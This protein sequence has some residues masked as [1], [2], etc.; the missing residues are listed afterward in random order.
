MKGFTVGFAILVWG[1]EAPPPPVQQSPGSSREIDWEAQAE[2]LF[3]R[4]V[5]LH[6]SL[7]R[8]VIQN[9]VGP[10]ANFELEPGTDRTP[11]T[12]DVPADRFREQVLQALADLD[13][14]VRWRTVD[15]R[16][17][18]EVGVTYVGFTI[19]LR[20]EQQATV[21]GEISET[22]P[23]SQ[24]SRQGFTA[25]WDGAKWRLELGPFRT[26]W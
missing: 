5:L 20:E 3:N 2:F 4:E 22:T 21:R 19:A 26:V 11:P 16:A 24:S 1:C 18:Q 14:P 10:A 6:A 25:I 9:T 23:G 7:Y 12:I 15:W 17:R 13:K 8:T